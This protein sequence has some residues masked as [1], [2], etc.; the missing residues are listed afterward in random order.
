MSQYNSGSITDR[1]PALIP[2]L[3]VLKDHLNDKQIKTNGD[4]K[5]EV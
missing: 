2:F 4:K 3:S 5:R 1:K